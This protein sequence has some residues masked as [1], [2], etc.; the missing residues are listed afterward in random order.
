MYN[1]KNG[2]KVYDKSDEDYLKIGI[3]PKINFPTEIKYSLA[4]ENAIIT[5]CK[6]YTTY[7]NNKN[8][9][10]HNFV[11][12][13]QDIGSFVRT[14]TLNVDA[15]IAAGTHKN[16]LNN[17]LINYDIDITKYLT[18]NNNKCFKL[19]I[20]NPKLLKLEKQKIRNKIL[21]IK[22]IS[23]INFEINTFLKSKEI[24]NDKTKI[25]ILNEILNNKFDNIL[26]NQ[27]DRFFKENFTIDGYNDQLIEN[28]ETIVKPDFNAIL[29]NSLGF[30]HILIPNYEF[31]NNKFLSINGNKYIDFYL[32]FDTNYFKPTDL[33]ILKYYN[34]NQKE[35]LTKILDKKESLLFKTDIKGWTPIYYAIDG[36]NYDIIN[37]I[38]KKNKNTLKHYDNKGITPIQ[39]C[40]N[41]QLHH[42]TNLFDDKDDIYYLTIYTNMLRNELKSND[43]L[44]PV[45]IESVF[46]I[47]LAIQNYKFYTFTPKL[48]KTI[49]DNTL[50]EQYKK[51]YVKNLHTNLY[52]NNPNKNYNKGNNENDNFKILHNIFDKFY[53]KAIELE[54]KNFELYG[55]YWKK[56]KI[57]KL[58]HIKISLE[59]KKELENISIESKNNKFNIPNYDEIKVEE[60][61]KKINTNKKYL[62][63]GL[64]FINTRFDEIKNVDYVIFLDKIYVHVLANII[65]VNFYLTMEELIV[66]HYINSDVKIEKDKIDNI[67]KLINNLLIN[68]KLEDN[69]INY[70]Y[71]KNPIPESVLKDKI[72][73]ILKNILFDDSELINNFETIVLPR[74]RDL[75]KITYKYLKMFMSN[76]HKFIYNQYH[77]LDI[78]LLLLN[79]LEFS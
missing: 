21:K 43:I 28:N 51:Y 7:N 44:I 39:L 47:A 6:D 67:L 41:K 54:S 58:E 74:Y 53:D 31:V 77:G 61:K 9:F 32:Y 2:L 45:N 10:F 13:F 29:L 5:R 15:A 48:P 14:I 38:L 11:L 70:S 27:I 36:N 56:F 20:S 34:S 24:Y 18:N 26:N 55:S 8:D 1:I 64:K 37:E 35:I 63:L 12:F 60:L 17:I 76:Y 62:D 52:L 19:Y 75:Y 22:N 59:L 25:K 33:K 57:K 16:L 72:K 42:L 23:D 46:I 66:K 30:E 73:E 78:L 4:D 3:Y 69:N 68:N 50:E 71:I 49:P 79:N 40:I 65:G